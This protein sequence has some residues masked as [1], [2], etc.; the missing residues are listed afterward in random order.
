MKNERSRNMQVRI[1]R[2]IS[3]ALSREDGKILL[4]YWMVLI[5]L[6]NTQKAKVHTHLELRLNK[7]W[8]HV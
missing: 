6:S 5:F 3:D 2:N 1:K 4:T 7:V 8:M